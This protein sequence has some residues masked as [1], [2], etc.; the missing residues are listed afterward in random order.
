MMGLRWAPRSVTG[1]TG[2]HHGL[3]MTI[4]KA[5]GLMEGTNSRQELGV[6]GITEYIW[7]LQGVPMECLRALL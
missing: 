5:C 3:V 6:E 2:G 4:S 1:A 7:V